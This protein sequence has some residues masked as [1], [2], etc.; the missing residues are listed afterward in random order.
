[1]LRDQVLQLYTPI[2]DEFM[3][4]SFAEEKQVH[5]EI[6]DSIEDKTMEHKV[7]GL[8]GLGLWEDAEEGEGGQ[9]DEPVLGYPKTFTQEKRRKRFRVSFE[10]V[11]QDEYALM[12]KVGT[13]EEMGRGARAKVEKDL[14]NFLS[15]GFATA[16]PDGQYLF[17][18]DHP[19]N[20]EETGITYD[21]LL[22]G[23]FS[24]DN[25]E[26]A[27]TDITNNF[28]GPDG[29]PIMPDE[30]PILL[31]PPAL[32]G[33]VKRVLSERA[34]ERP[35]TANRDINR[36]AGRYRP[37]EWRWLAAAFGGSDTAWYII[38]PSM[39]MLK[40][41]WSKK[42]HYNSWLDNEDEFYVFSGRMLYDFG[43]TNWRFGF[44]STGV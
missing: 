44:A 28:I 42:P 39:K 14:A 34:E 41:V 27:E 18:T 10:A 33:A 21:N 11:D 12:N 9:Y 19:K 24:H 37:I 31:Y 25:L 26:A 22:S 16:G 15:D 29:I 30:D 7:D 23:A 13:A 2:Y 8:G 17:D 4:E 3:L 1:M 5:P 43:A 36:F 38:Y 6:Y 35:G 20:S 32:R 40:I